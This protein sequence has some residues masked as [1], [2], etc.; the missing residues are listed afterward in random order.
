[1]T[2]NAGLYSKGLFI[3]LTTTCFSVFGD[4]KNQEAPSSKPIG[5]YF[6]GFGG[7]AH[8]NT[9]HG[10]QEGTAFIDPP[11]NVH[12]E[13]SI[14]SSNIG[15]GGLH[16]GYEWIKKTSGFRITPGI[17]LEGYYFANTRKD[18]FINE[19]DRLDE[20]DFHG[21]LPM[22]VGVALLNAIVAFENDYITPYIGLGGGA[23]MISIHGADSSQLSPPE[24]GINHFN[25]DPNAFNWT[26]AFQA[27][28]GL[29]Y[30][31]GKYWRIFG[32]YRFLYL[33][34]THYEFGSTQYPTHAKTSR[35]KVDLDNLFYNGFSL[36]IDFTF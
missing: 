7:W 4:K 33:P 27:K 9:S 16:L 34:W 21:T 20:H 22:R 35:W 28:T 24:P 17:E 3:L 32:E 15:F 1:M 18:I 8:A 10:V 13:G 36:G 26:Y 14:D 23:T 29:R 25:S 2:Y 5:I 19:S 12:A 30:Q 31:I 11:L 6:G